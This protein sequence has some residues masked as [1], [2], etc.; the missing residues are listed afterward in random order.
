MSDSNFFKHPSVCDKCGQTLHYRYY[1][2]T[3]RCY[4]CDYL[5]IP[6]AVSDVIV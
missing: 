3:M 4:N 1:K 6:T 2:Q 5:R